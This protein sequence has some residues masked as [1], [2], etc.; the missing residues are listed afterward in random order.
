MNFVVERILF[1]LYHTDYQSQQT[2]MKLAPITF[3]NLSLL[4][5][6]GLSIMSMAVFAPHTFKSTRIFWLQVH[7]QLSKFM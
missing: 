5:A 3:G 2:L 1:V 6:W 7:H 4:S